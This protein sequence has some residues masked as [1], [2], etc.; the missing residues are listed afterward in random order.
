MMKPQRRITKSR[1][2]LAIKSYGSFIN[3][4]VYRMA[5]SPAQADEFRSYALEE[6]L[7]CM[8]CYKH[9]HTGIY[10][11]PTT[12]FSTFFHDRIIGAFL[13]AREAE[14]RANRSQLVP[15]ETMVTIPTTMH[16]MDT[17]ILAGECMEC[18]T[19]EEK[20]VITE[21]FF[22]GRTMREI[23]NARGGVHST[24]YRIKKRAIDKMKRKFRVD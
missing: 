22:K 11:A 6:L 20:D 18:L 5:V 15:V 13:H 3:R 12:N 7:K 8:I 23:S 10:G 16:D 1:F 17:N 19:K 21:L 9:G 2:N 4:F 14:K 24:I